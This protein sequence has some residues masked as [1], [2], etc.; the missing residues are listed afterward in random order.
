MLQR[1]AHDEHSFGIGF[2]R[3]ATGL[4]DGARLQMRFGSTLS[5]SHSVT[6]RDESGGTSAP[7]LLRTQVGA[8]EIAEVVARSTGIPVSKL[9]QGEREKLLK[10][11]DILSAQVIGP[12]VKMLLDLV[13]ATGPVGPAIIAAVSPSGMAA[14]V[15]PRGLSA[16]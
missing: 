13:N 9:M 3:A 7:T 12:L 14:Q 16:T 15:A 6:D 11:E 5:S 2:G 8:E 10:M 4:G 1:S